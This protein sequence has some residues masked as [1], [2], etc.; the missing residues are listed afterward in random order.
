LVADLAQADE[1]LAYVR[2]QR[3]GGGRSEGG[4]GMRAYTGTEPDYAYTGSDGMKLKGVIAGGPA[5]KAGVKPGDIVVEV[6]GLAVT[7]VHEY[8][9]A[10]GVLKPDETVKI[11][12][13]RDGVRQELTITPTA[14]D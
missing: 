10:L 14:R 2:V 9:Y 11:A 13:L 3:T 4:A 1:R 5:D 6:A 7:N 8:A 12:V